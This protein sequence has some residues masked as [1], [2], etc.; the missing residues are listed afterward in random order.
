MKEIS[1]HEKMMKRHGGSGVMPEMKKASYEVVLKGKKQIAEDT[2]SFT[3]EKPKGFKFKA[4][5]HI[6][7]TLLDPPETDTEGDSRFLSLAST[8]GDKDLLIAMRMRDTAFKRVLRDMPVGSKVLIQILLGVPHGA[9]ALHEDA[10]RPAVYIVGGI[11]IVPAYSMIKDA[12]ERKLP[13]KLYLFYSNRRPEDAPF[14]GELARLSEQNPNFKLIATMTEPEKAASRW[15][16]L[17]G[18]IDSNLLRKYIDDLNAPIY[19]ISGLPEMVSAMKAMLKSAGVSESSVQAEEFTGFNLNELQNGTANKRPNHLLIALIVLVIISLLIVH[20]T[21]LRSLLHSGLNSFSLRN[22][23]SYLAILLI[24][25]I[26]A[27][28]LKLFSMGFRHG[29]N[30]RR[31]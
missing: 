31:K 30:K 1:L 25:I 17:T 6:R 22:P 29:L 12:A 28:K 5:Q 4:G 21:A 23:V 16:G 2:M 18:R 3:F 14:L 10:S 13:H 26:F 7:M 9:F 20:V 24:L 15:D 8:P 27:V 11:G 19:Y